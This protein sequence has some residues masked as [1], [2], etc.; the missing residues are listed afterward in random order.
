MVGLYLLYII[1]G[2]KGYGIIVREF[3]Y[4]NIG[5]D[6]PDVVGCDC[7]VGG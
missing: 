5:G 3:V 2:G 1:N 7:S 6:Y 4:G